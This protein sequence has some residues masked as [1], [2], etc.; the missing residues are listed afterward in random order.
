MCVRVCVCV[1][2]AWGLE[3]GWFATFWNKSKGTSEI[4]F[5]KYGYYTYFIGM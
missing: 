2:G 5:S 1:C 3:G 4:E